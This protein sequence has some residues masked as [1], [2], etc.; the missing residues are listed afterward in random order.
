MR[1]DEECKA[2]PMLCQDVHVLKNIAEIF[3]DT[4]RLRMRERFPPSPTFGDA[5]CN[6]DQIDNEFSVSGEVCVA[7]P[8]HGQLT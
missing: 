5:C 7:T 6:A 8:E 3:G 2:L 1:D 4:L